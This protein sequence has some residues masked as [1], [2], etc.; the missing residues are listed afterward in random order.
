MAYDLA[1]QYAAFVDAEYIS[2][3]VTAILETGK[4]MYKPLGANQLLIPKEDITG[5]YSYDRTN[6]GPGIATL[7]NEYETVDLKMDRGTEVWL[8]V[9]DAD[10]AK[11]SIARKVALFTKKRMVPEIDAYR[12]H[13]I[14]QDKG[15][16]DAFGTLTYDTVMAAINTGV[17]AMN[18][19]EVDK[20]GRILYVNNDILQL[21]I[22]SGEWTNMRSVDM[23]NG[24]IDTRIVMYNG[25]RVIPVVDSRFYFTQTFGEGTNTPTGSLLNFMI[26]EPSAVIAVVKYSAAYMFGPGEHTIKGGHG[27]YSAP[28]TYHGAQLL[29]N[30][31]AGV[32]IH[33]LTVEA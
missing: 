14:C 6:V 13:K 29:E 25:M 31:T 1:K 26:V 23:A 19:A 20:D 4:E 17:K 22:D 18:K 30:K 9:L 10:E 7:T 8:D 12:F 15:A 16:S 27:F 5:C 11:D 32:Y 21:M 33:T 3:A 28:R 24:I 2:G